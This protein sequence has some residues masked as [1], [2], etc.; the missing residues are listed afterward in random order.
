MK[1]GKNL[2]IRKGQGKK[3]FDR[4]A[5]SVREIWLSDP[6]WPPKADLEKALWRF[7]SVR[8][9]MYAAEWKLSPCRVRPF[10]GGVL[11]ILPDNKYGCEAGGIV[12]TRAITGLGDRI[13]ALPEGVKPAAV[14]IIALSEDVVP[15]A[16]ESVIDAYE[17]GDIINARFFVVANGQWQSADLDAILRYIAED[18]IRAGGP[19]KVCKGDLLLFRL[20]KRS[21]ELYREGVV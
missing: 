20:Y 12:I 6:T 21:V 11:L 7:I 17:Y 13:R 10:P 2:K 19:A 9:G 16:V 4:A 14:E 8:A 18:A 1:T 5:N 15:A 3:E